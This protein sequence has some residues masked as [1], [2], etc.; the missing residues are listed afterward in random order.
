MDLGRVGI[1][2]YHLNYQMVIATG[3]ANIWARDPFTM[4]AAQLT[5]T[6]AYPEWFLLG[7]GVSHARLVQGIRGHRYQQ[8]LRA[9]RR[10]LDGMDEA[11]RAYRAVKPAATPPRVL[12]ALGPRMLALAA[13]RAQ[14]AHPYLVHPSTRQR[15][16]LLSA[17][18]PGCCQSKPWS[19][20]QTSL[21]LGRSAGGT[22]LDTSTCRTT[23]ITGAAS[24]SPKTTSW[25]R[26]ATGW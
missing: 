19:W 15:L 24:A 2:T 4:T 13:E 16:A 23:R 21:R 26:A 25:G 18:I 1:W 17:P 11:T 3:I 8:P 5:L 6:E 7:L 10:Y 22:F 20:K 9:M 14:G 12:A